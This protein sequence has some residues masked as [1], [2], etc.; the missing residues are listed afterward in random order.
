MRSADEV[1]DAFLQR[2]LFYA[3]QMTLAWN[4]AQEVS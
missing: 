1:L 4:L 3:K 2:V